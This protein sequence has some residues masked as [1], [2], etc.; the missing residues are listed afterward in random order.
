MKSDALNGER[1]RRSLLLAICVSR[2]LF[3]GKSDAGNG[4]IRH[5]ASF[6]FALRTSTQAAVIISFLIFIKGKWQ[7]GGCRPADIYQILSN[8]KIRTAC[9]HR[10][11]GRST[12]FLILLTLTISYHRLISLA[13]NDIYC[14]EGNYKD[15]L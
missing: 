2:P 3:S 10:K 8:N 5:S 9:L 11:T 13:E 12:V 14:H 15:V 6:S 4:G 1:L 7:L